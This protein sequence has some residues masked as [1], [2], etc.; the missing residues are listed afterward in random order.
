VFKTSSV[1]LGIPENLGGLEE[2]YRRPD[3]ATVIGLVTANKALAETKEHRRK[4]RTHVNK[5]GSE[6]VNIFKKLKDALF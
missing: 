4:N 5:S 6:K 3:F 1:R 2:K